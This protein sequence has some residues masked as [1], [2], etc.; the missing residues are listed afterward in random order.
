MAGR[1]VERIVLVV[2]VVIVVLFIVGGFSMMAGYW[3]GGYGWGGMMGRGMMGQSGMGYGRWIVGGLIFLIIL[4]AG[5][6]LILSSGE[7][8]EAHANRALEILKE[9][10]AKGEITDEEFKRMKKELE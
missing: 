3:G 9:R 7:T 6:Y 4:A 10:Y 8:R 2:A 1:G 5:L